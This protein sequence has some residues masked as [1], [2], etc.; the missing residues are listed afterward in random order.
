MECL[1][2]SGAELLRALGFIFR[3]KTLCWERKQFAVSCNLRTKV[4]LAFVRPPPPLLPPGMSFSVQDS[5]M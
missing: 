2:S 5:S 3:L 1:W 4:D